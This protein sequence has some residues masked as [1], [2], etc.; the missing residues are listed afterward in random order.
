MQ[1]YKRKSP[2][3]G[4]MKELQSPPVP[5][6]GGMAQRIASLEQRMDAAGKKRDYVQLVKLMDETRG[7]IEKVQIV[8]SALEML[9]SRVRFSLLPDAM[10]ESDIE[11]FRVD[12]IG[13]CYLQDDVSVTILNR[14]GAKDW[15]IKHEL[16]DLV[17]ETINSSTLAAYVRRTIKE[18][19]ALPK[20]L[21]K[22]LKVKPVTRA[23]ITK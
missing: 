10:T 17:T 11:N 22:M 6:V 19:G 23:V 8:K 21:A 15:F 5:A 14:E 1:K 9:Y 2:K 3:T 16:E 4:S 13:Q 20:A 18:K 12:G 7:A